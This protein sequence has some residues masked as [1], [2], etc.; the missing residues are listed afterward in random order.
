MS[1][2]PSFYNPQRIG[3]LF[4]PDVTAIARDAA[5]TNLRPKT[6]TMCIWSSLICK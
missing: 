4:Y 5:Q 1:N 3:T 6:K 2:F